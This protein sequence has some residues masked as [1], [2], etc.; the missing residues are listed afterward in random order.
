ME[1]YEEDYTA[2]EAEEEVYTVAVEDPTDSVEFP[3]DSTLKEV[4]PYYEKFDEIENQVDT[5]EAE[6][7]HEAQYGNE[8]NVEVI[9]TE[10]D[11]LDNKEDY[12]ANLTVPE[13]MEESDSGSDIIELESEGST[14]LEVDEE[15]TDVIPVDEL[16][17]EE[18]PS[19]D[20]LSNVDEERAMQDVIDLKIA[21]DAGGA[22]P[23][24]D[25][26]Y[27]AAEE[28]LDDIVIPDEDDTQEQTE[29]KLR[30]DER[31]EQMADSEEEDDMIILS[32]GYER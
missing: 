15:R 20:T 6:L 28:Q 2:S 13:E 27:E 8:E 24:M 26:G 19:G 9:Q 17:V 16:L 31:Q 11:I 22:D 23:D 3:E 18:Y 29:S 7:A 4:E 25:F 12:Y 32:D 14:A 10:L 30:M 1:E 21:S 5:L